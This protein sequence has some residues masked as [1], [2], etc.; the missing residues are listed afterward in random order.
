MGLKFITEFPPDRSKG[1]SVEQYS[2]ALGAAISTSTAALYAPLAGSNF[3][4]GIYRLYDVAEVNYWTKAVIAAFSEYR[5]RVICFGRDW[6][7]N[8]FCLDCSNVNQGQVPVLLFEIATG[9]VLRIPETFDSFH[10]KLLIEEPNAAVAKRLFVE[11]IRKD[12]RPLESRE[13]VGYRVP[14][15]LGGAD[16]LENLERM[17]VEVY[18]SLTEQLLEKSRNLPMGTELNEISGSHEN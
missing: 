15:F 1:E 9:Q 7:C 18:W 14:L 11:W 10:E 3:G 4:S 6:L 5:G 16:E 2:K 8:Q 17:D 12:R 13:C